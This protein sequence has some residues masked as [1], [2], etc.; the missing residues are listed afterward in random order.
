M[1]SCRFFINGISWIA[2]ELQQGKVSRPN[3]TTRA[4]KFHS[5]SLTSPRR[6]SPFLC[7][8]FTPSPE[9]PFPFVPVN[10]L[11]MCWR[12]VCTYRMNASIHHSIMS[13]RVVLHLPIISK[14]GHPKSETESAKAPMGSLP[15]G[16]RFYPTEEELV[17]FYLRKKV[18]GMSAGD[19]SRLMDRVIPTLD[20]YEF[21]PWDLP[22]K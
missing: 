13:G 16:Y 4:W 20:I 1:I 5:K 21:N 19:L 14:L 8:S 22:R 15:P 11:V 10:S 2:S 7:V 17:H 12:C 18:D 6:Q 9:L 3:L